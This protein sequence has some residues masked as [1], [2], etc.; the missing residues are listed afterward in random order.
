MIKKKNSPDVNN[1][2]PTVPSISNMDGLISSETLSFPESD[3]EPKAVLE[4]PSFSGLDTLDVATAVTQTIHEVSQEAFHNLPE[5]PDY[6]TESVQKQ[7]IPSFLDSGTE[8]QNE[9]ELADEIIELEN[10]ADTGNIPEIPSFSHESE[11][12]ELQNLPDISE[13]IAFSQ[14]A[15]HLQDAEMAIPER[16]RNV[17]F[18]G[19]LQEAAKDILMHV[20]SVSDLSDLDILG[21]SGV[22]AFPAV[23]AAEPDESSCLPEIPSVSYDNWEE[24]IKIETKKSQ[25]ES[26]FRQNPENEETVPIA[27]LPLSLNALH[28]LQKIEIHDSLELLETSQ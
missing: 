26:A 9:Q 24:K 19:D 16:P 21:V 25:T 15:P 1:D 10:L 28:Y 4:I 22:S 14:D 11:L 6:A 2:M 23:S 13:F 20:P 17:V 5:I 3:A 12:Q 18:Q 7:L 8:M 27:E